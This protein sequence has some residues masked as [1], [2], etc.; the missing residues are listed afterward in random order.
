VQLAAAS[1]RAEADR[2]ASRFARLHPRVEEAIVPGKGR[3]FRVRVG[4]FDTKEAAQRYL[5]DVGRE[6][7]AK[8][9]VVP[10]R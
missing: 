8:G 4:G 1:D 9:I 7:G 5:Q 3:F 2:L 6:T 10:N